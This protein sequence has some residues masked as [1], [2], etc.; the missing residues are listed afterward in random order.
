MVSYS[1]VI[2]Q[3]AS[4][5]S[6]TLLAYIHVQALLEWMKKNRPPPQKKIINKTNKKSNKKTLIVHSKLTHVYC[7]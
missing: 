4:N 3:Y 2:L 5:P 6:S 1:S 7:V